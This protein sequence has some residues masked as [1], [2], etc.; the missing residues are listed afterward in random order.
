MKEENC[1]LNFIKLKMNIPKELSVYYNP[2]RIE[3]SELTP[4]L[5]K[6]DDSVIPTIEDIIIEA[7]KAFEIEE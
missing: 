4:K 2:D 3:E 7:C 5:I 1:N 6:F